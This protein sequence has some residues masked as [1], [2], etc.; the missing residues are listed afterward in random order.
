MGEETPLDDWV[1]I[2]AKRVRP[3]GSV[4][5]IHRVERLDALIAA[6]SRHL[7][8]LEL[9]PL[10][11][12]ANRPAQLALLRARKDGRAAFRLYHGLLVHAGARHSGDRADYT[13]EASAIL[14]DAG[15]L[16]FASA[17]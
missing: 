6:F 9:K 17:D 12:R 13:P 11:P 1:A 16:A 15:P 2:A 7:G 10:T 14:S 3:G 8:S 5:F 4:T